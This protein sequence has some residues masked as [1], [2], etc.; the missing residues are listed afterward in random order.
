MRPVNR[1]RSA[2]WYK[3]F[4]PWFLIALPASVVLAGFYTLFLANRYA[5]D[6]VVDDYYR[7]GLAINRELKRQRAAENRGI[8][9]K[10]SQTNRELTIRVTGAVDA[11]QLR[12]QLSHPLEAS[13]DFTVPVA[14][15]S[16]DTY[17]V[18]LPE[19]LS[20]RWHWILDIGEASAWRL[21][22]EQRF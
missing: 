21:D 19:P 16:T 14:R 15:R 22:G 17:H 13:Q 11:N 18:M 5:D 3:Q 9:A 6:L 1:D 8:T 10:V 4:W 20:G 2:P 12:L 7:E